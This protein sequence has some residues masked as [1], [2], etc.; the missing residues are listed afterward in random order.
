MTAPNILF[1]HAGRLRSGWRLAIF[2][3]VYFVALSFF[4]ALV[5][6]TLSMFAGSTERA[7]ALLSSGWGFV[8]QASILF[9]TA[10]LIGWVAGRVFEDLPWRALGWKFH[11]GWL[12]DLAFGSLVGAL[13]V[14]VA[15][16]FAL[17]AGGFSFAPA[18]AALWPVVLKTMA[19][20]GLIFVVSAAAEE[21]LFR[22]YPLQTALRAWP[23]W[24]ALIPSSVMFAGVHLGNPNVARGFTFVNTALAGVW[25]AVAYLRTRSLWFPLGVHWAWNWTTGALLGLPV[26]GITSIT[27]APLLR[28]TDN[29]PAWLTGGAYGIEGGLA[30]TLALIISTLFI[31]RTSLLTADEELRQ[32]TD[33][34]I[35]RPPA[36]SIGI[37]D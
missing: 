4:T 36:A 10:S 20:A 28:A 8:A 32:L 34:E 24:V 18:S 23:A 12:R 15:T 22:G 3:A 25:L 17:A 26:S 30:C 5:W 14:G 9:T 37:R 11:R 1:N 6:T 31:W 16:V 29:G 27:P 2:V 21:A 19:G 35:P 7:D 13:S 33:A